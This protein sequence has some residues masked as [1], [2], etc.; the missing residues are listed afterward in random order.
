MG[1]HLMKSL[2]ITTGLRGISYIFSIMIKAKIT[3]K[4]LRRIISAR[5]RK[6]T[7]NEQPEPAGLDSPGVGLD[8]NAV[9]TGAVDLI[10]ALPK[11]KEPKSIKKVTTNMLAIIKDLVH[12][13]ED[14]AVLQKLDNKAMLDEI[15]PLISTLISYTS[16]TA[17]DA[18]G[19]DRDPTV[20]LDSL[21]KRATDA[22]KRRVD[23]YMD[24]IGAGAEADQVIAAIVTAVIGGIKKRIVSGQADIVFPE[25]E[26]PEPEGS[27]K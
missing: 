6:S 19:K 4:Y 2:W 24:E 7:L 8:M 12:T 25:P 5:L 21:R 3:E 27:K 15:A 26:E 10:P 23:T 16:Y 13:L 9:I 11:F 17:A 14:P 18:S 1:V 20:Y 22:T